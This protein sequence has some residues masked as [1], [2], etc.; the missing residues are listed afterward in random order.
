MG[1]PPSFLIKFDSLQYT[2]L[3]C[4]LILRVKCPQPDEVNSVDKTAVTTTR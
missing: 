1:S 2:V 4:F 3:L